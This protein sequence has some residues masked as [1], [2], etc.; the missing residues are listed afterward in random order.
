MVR[1]FFPADVRLRSLAEAM[2]AGM[3]FELAQ[4]EERVDWLDL[5]A[6][7]GALARW[8]DIQIWTHAYSVGPLVG[9][10][11]LVEYRALVGYWLEAKHRLQNPAVEAKTGGK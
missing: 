1:L 9:D 3:R 5:V 10:G 8:P 11:L 7:L 4:P 6:R 2:A